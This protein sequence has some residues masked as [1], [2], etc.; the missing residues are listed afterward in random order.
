MD[1]IVNEDNTFDFLTETI[2]VRFM[3][4][5]KRGIIRIF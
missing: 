2:D 1:I 4:R 3:R 5:A